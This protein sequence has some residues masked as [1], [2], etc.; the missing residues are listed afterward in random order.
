MTAPIGVVV[1]DDHPVFR[2]GFA[3]L[4]ASIDDIE[5]LG[6]AAD[7]E[8][9]LALVAEVH[10]QVVVMDVQMPV[11]DGI[12]ATRRLAETHP[13]V[14]VVVLTMSEEDDTI[15][16]AVRAGARGYL[17]KGAEPEE[18]VRAVST[19][20][21]GG[22]VFGAV[23]ATRITEF[24]ARPLQRRVW[25]SPSC[26]LVNVRCSTSSRRGCPTARSQLGSSSPRRP[27]ATTSARYS[28]SCGR[29]TVP[30]PSC[31]GGTRDSGDD[32]L[33]EFSQDG[34]LEVRL[35]AA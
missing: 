35:C 6:T 5:V 29:L 19:V 28:A 18:V 34:R 22:V 16:D 23:L 27:Y 26:P 32:A 21:A 31:A 25:P 33:H 15:V 30:R 20:A 4:L 10:P 12:E 13:E 9:A 7:G 11:L 24:F 3:A 17:L 2:Q 1:V 8:Q 14:G